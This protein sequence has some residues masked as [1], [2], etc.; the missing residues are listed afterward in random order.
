[1]LASKGMTQNTNLLWFKIDFI[2]QGQSQ[3]RWR[4]LRPIGSLTVPSI[5]MDRSNRYANRPT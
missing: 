4:G 1:M 3:G 5:L 2:W